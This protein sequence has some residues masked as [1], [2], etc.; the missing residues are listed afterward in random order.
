MYIGWR[1]HKI[2]R[3]EYGV[4]ITLY[5]NDCINPTKVLN[6]IKTY[7]KWHKLE[8]IPFLI[9]THRNLLQ[10]CFPDENKNISWFNSVEELENPK[11]IY[12]RKNKQTS[13]E[14]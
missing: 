10:F 11:V 6:A 12:Q 9:T 8:N 1:G 4:A 14:N 7:A 3:N 13:F 5:E 2:A